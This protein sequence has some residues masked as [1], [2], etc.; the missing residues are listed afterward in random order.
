VHVTTSKG[1][2]SPSSQTTQYTYK[3]AQVWH[4][5][6]WTK[7]DARPCW[8]IEI[9]SATRTRSRGPNSLDSNSRVQC[10]HTQIQPRNHISAPVSAPAEPDA[11]RNSRSSRVVLHRVV[12]PGRR[13]APRRQQSVECKPGR[14]V[15]RR[16]PVQA[17]HKL[18]LRIRTQ[19]PPNQQPMRQPLKTLK[20]LLLEREL[21]S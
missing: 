4:G 2:P 9:V 11:E 20:R 7:L 10:T 12:V 3:S 6:A 15:V 5:G 18:G 17:P 8:A 21:Y 16:T 14:W 19:A 13:A 1:G